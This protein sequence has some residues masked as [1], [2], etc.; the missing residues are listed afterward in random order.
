M[1]RL[2]VH[3]WFTSKRWTRI[4]KL[5]NKWKSTNSTHTGCLL[6][7]CIA[8]WE[9]ANT[10]CRRSGWKK[11]SLYAIENSLFDDSS[12]HLMIPHRNHFRNSECN[13]SEWDVIATKFGMKNKKK[14]NVVAESLLS[15]TIFP[16]YFDGKK[17]KTFWMS[18]MG[19]EREREI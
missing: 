5:I 6:L 16:A 11:S 14:T 1:N 10:V 12:M 8:C 13:R 9:E 15:S 7:M 2:L 19:S 18:S 3:I 17:T 4:P